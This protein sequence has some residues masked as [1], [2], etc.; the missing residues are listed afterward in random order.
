[1]TIQ[2]HGNPK[3]ENLTEATMTLFNDARLKL[4]TLGLIH[5]ILAVPTSGILVVVVPY[6]R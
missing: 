5:V 2:S 3:S 6:A 4:K 1:M